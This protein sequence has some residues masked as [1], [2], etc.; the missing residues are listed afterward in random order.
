MESS[1][2]S[3]SE[4]LLERAALL[5]KREYQVQACGRGMGLV[6]VGSRKQ[7]QQDLL[8]VA[9]HGSERV[10]RECILPPAAEILQHGQEVQ[11]LLLQLV[12]LSHGSFL[13]LSSFQLLDVS[14]LSLTL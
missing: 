10:R 5:D 1:G 12:C 4:V 7:S 14:W 9:K 13:A 11:C 3:V 6:W 2:E 8:C